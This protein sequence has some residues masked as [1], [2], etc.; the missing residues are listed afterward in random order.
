[1]TT[2]SRDKE[3]GVSREGE[4]PGILHAQSG[5]DR[6]VRLLPHTRN[7][8]AA[9]AAKFLDTLATWALMLALVLAVIVAA[10]SMA[11]LLGKMHY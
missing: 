2:Q 4:N 9:E 3:R 8:I 10:L 11:G 6:K 5:N 7:L 1:L